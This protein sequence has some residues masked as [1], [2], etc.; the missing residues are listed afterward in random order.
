MESQANK[1][2]SLSERPQLIDS[3]M[4]APIEVPHL[5]ICFAQRQILF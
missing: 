4:F 3:S 5:K 1:E 2:N